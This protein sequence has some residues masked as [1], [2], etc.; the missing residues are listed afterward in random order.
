MITTLGLIEIPPS[1]AGRTPQAMWSNYARRRLAGVSLI[2]WVVR[3]VSE[4]ARI[5][6]VAVL[7]PP[8]A[9]LAELRRLVP[10]YVPV[11]VGEREDPLACLV[12]AARELQP[13]AVVHFRMNHPFVD[14]VL[15]DRLVAYAESRT[16]LDYAS[17][18]S[19]FATRQIWTRVGLFGEWCRYAA[20]LRAE[21][22]ATDELDREQVT[23]FLYGNPRQFQLGFKWLPAEIDRED[24][25]LVLA[26]EED[27]EH[28]WEIVDA[29]GLDGSDWRTV[30]GLLEHQP[31]MR[32]RMQLLNRAEEEVASARAR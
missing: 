9:D 17:Y 31:A 1:A 23:R 18:G 29:L 8:E 4:C 10:A 16:G 19:R 13:R 30:A 21:S 20:L 22:L 3:R 15:T 25:R 5:D 28:A 11:L 27:W 6:A 26:G 14:P 2:E 12:N 24:L 32:S 7:A